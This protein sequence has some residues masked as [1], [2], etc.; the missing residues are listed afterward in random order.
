[1]KMIALV[2]LSLQF[3]IFAAWAQS[4]ANVFAKSDSPFLNSNNGRS[5]VERIDA[6]VAQINSLMK[7]VQT[8]RA[9]VEALKSRVSAVEDEN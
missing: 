3:V 6:N 5:K 7:E 9:E 2:V 1:M 4:G 8:L